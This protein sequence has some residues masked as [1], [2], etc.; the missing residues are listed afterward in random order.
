MNIHPAL[1]CHAWVFSDKGHTQSSMIYL[2]RLP[3]KLSHSSSPDFPM[4]L[5]YREHWTWNMGI[6]LPRNISLSPPNHASLGLWASPTNAAAGALRL[7][8]TPTRACDENDPPL[9]NKQNGRAKK[10]ACLL[11]GRERASGREGKCRRGSPFGTHLAPSH[12]AEAPT[13]TARSVSSMGRERECRSGT[14]RK[15]PGKSRGQVERE[16]TPA[17]GDGAK[18][19]RIRRRL[20]NCGERK[21]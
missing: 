2:I 20:W 10:R 4:Q 8:Q 3:H 11:K 12:L 19:R 13:Q 21:K 1:D 16:E 15:A 7:R 18:W 5:S 14:L 6:S 17:R 9:V